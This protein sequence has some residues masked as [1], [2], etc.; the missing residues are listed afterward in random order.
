MTTLQQML[1]EEYP[2]RPG[3]KWMLLL[4]VV[5]IISLLIS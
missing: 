4:F 5:V 3:C 2:Q 1:N